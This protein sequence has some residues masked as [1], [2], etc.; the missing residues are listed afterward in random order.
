[1]M[2]QYL[3]LKQAHPG[4]I[5]MFRLG[6]FYEMFFDDAQV[7]SRVLEITLTSRDKGEGAVP[8]C[9]VPWHAA[10]AHIARLVESG[11]KVAVCDQVE[12]PRQA[13]GLVRREVVQVVTPGLVTDTEMIDAKRAQYLLALHPGRR[14]VGFSY[15]D[16]TTGEFRVGE[17]RNWEAAAAEVAR[18]EPR[19]V[20][21]AEGRRSEIPADA[22]PPGVPVAEVPGRDFDGRRARAALRAHFGVA[23]LAGYGVEDLD[24]GVKAAAAVLRYVEAHCKGGLATLRRLSRHRGGDSLVLDEATKRNLELFRT[25]SGERREGS[26]LHLADRTCTA[27]GGRRLREWLAFPLLDVGAIDGRL[28]AVDELVRRGET[29]RKVRDTLRSVHDLARLGGKAAQ[30]TANARDLVALRRSL[31]AVPGLAALLGGAEA[32]LLGEVA[33]A[34]DPLPE[35]A[36]LLARAL[37]DDPPAVL[38]EGGLLRDG[39]HPEVDELR[40]IQR[41]G[42]G[43]IAR[44]QARERE[45][46]GIA[47]LKVGFN[48]VFGYFLEVTRANLA[49]VPPDYERRQTL[50]NAERFVTPQLKDMEQKVLGAEDRARALEYEGFVEVRRE[51]ARHL[52]RLQATARA[53]EILDV[54]ASFAD[55]AVERGYVRPRVHA[56]VGIELR[57]GRHPVVE[58]LGEE[59]FVP[60]DVCVAGEGA[61]LLI[62]TGPNMA[63]KSTIL[64]QTAL[65]VL[66]AQAGSFVPAESAR[67]GAVDRIFTRVGA[68][69]DLARGRSTFMVEMTETANILH[70]A[71]G[72]SLIVLDEIGRGTSTFDGL[73]IAWAVA[74]YLHE[75]GAP[76]LFATHYHELTDLAR[77][78]PGVANWNVAVKEW[79]G[80]VIFLRRL[81]EGGASRSYG[82]QV[83][84]LAGLPDRVLGRAREVL[85]N[86]E[87]GE[88]DE[89]GQPRF[90][91]SAR[92]RPG[93]ARRGPSQLSLFASAAERRRDALV[94]ELAGQSV[95]TL[96]PVE[97]LV[98][99]QD[100]C[101]RARTLISEGE[102]P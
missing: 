25:L 27:M 96:T 78:L 9:G 94:R 75:L 95:D 30:G 28:D 81:V 102:T 77:T 82:I 101:D 83:A 55:L 40:A 14:G 68:S 73:S 23:G 49:A 12:D 59:R 52:D 66:L 1:M 58:A 19:E 38:T 29:R 13:K 22:L 43:W 51:T 92:V 7:A 10:R 93:A 89:V 42:R 88:L 41:D 5:L 71:T 60:N 18:I 64:R 11:H 15:A 48:K 36:G 62:L 47:S 17:A 100:L 84:R 46:T 26:L 61:H 80:Q 34:L 37:A 87:A 90:A 97:A 39:Y 24:E 54:L 2:R 8:M 67:V 98:R 99:L 3:E 4:C 72:R 35:V 6:D 45:R 70:N 56:G 57:G 20:L 65:I 63:G 31:E 85:G 32:A 79:E 21:V 76:T 74:E 33:G 69:D 44:L 91:L 16:V 53:V 50:A 86:L